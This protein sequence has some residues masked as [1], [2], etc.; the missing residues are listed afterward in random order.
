MSFPLPGCITQGKTREEALE[1]AK[2]AIVGYIATLEDEGLPVP[3]ERFETFLVAVRASCCGSPDAT[4]SRHSAKS[5]S[6]R[7][8]STAVTSSSVA[9]TPSRSSS[10]PP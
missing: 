5:A 4:V 10:L 6:A 3:E 1:N 7:N 9:T 8:A 2:E